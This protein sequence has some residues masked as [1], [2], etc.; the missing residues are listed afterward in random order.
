MN[1]TIVNY[2]PFVC[3]KVKDNYLGQSGDAAYPLL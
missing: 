3:D 1:E 2:Q